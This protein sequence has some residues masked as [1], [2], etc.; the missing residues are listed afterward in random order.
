MA[1]RNKLFTGGAIGLV[2]VGAY[3]LGSLFNGFGLG[4]GSGPG[5][6]PGNGESSD[7][8]QVVTSTEEPEPETQPVSKAEPSGVELGRMVVVLIDGQEYKVLKAPDAN[9][10]DAANYRPATLE[11]IVQMA[12]DVEGVQGLR[13]RIGMRANST[14]KAEADLQNALIA[15]GL[16]TTAFRELDETIP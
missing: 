14:A 2:L 5:E 4:P 6:G 7:P 10:Y 3:Y 16:S 12:K 1:M 13:V 8:S 9:I 11:Q 15:G